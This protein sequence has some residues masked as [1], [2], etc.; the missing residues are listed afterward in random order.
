M[1]SAGARRRVWITNDRGRQISLEALLVSA[2]DR[3]PIVAE[4]KI[5]GDQNLEFGLVQALAAAAQLSSEPQLHRLHD[6]Y[7]NALGESAPTR[8]DVYV[9]AARAPSR[10]S[11]R[12]SH[13]A[14]ANAPE[15]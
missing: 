9:I 4:I 15:R 8:L 14:L 7:R 1:S 3:T 6:Q 13:G 12:S 11:A 2:E 10:A 5:G